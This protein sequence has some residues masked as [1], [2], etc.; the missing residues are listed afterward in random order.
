MRAQSRL[1]GLIES[2]VAR[3]DSPEQTIV[4]QKLRRLIDEWSTRSDVEIYWDDYNRR[5]SLLMSAEQFAAITN[6]DPDYDP[7]GLGQALWPTPNSMREVEPGAPFV[8]RRIL[9]T[10]GS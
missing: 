9:K 5:T 3:V 7:E 8:L 6:A 2:R 1:L 4:A 10:E